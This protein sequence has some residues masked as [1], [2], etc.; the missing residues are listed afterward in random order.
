MSESR[1]GGRLDQALTDIRGI[2][3]RLDDRSRPDGEPSPERQALDPELLRQDQQ[4][5]LKLKGRFAAWALV[6][7][8][9]QLVAANVAFY[10]TVALSRKHPTSP[11][12]LAE[13]WPM[14][15]PRCALVVPSDGED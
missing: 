3:E 1:E 9:F 8:G 11:R 10:N 2:L 14:W 13:T 4:Q 12:F 15:S 7:M 5:D 6:G